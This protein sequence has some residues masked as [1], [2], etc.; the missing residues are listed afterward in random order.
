MNVIKKYY[1]RLTA[2]I[3]NKLKLLY[4][5]I[6]GF[7]LG[8]V[9]I[10]RIVKLYFFNHYAKSYCLSSKYMDT[11]NDSEKIDMETNFII[12]TNEL[13]NILELRLNNSIKIL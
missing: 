12:T 10:L 1:S 3:E 9:Y 7:Y 2:K 4:I 11:N 5:L 8:S 13:K 6:I